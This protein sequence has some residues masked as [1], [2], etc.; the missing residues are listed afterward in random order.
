MAPTSQRWVAGSG[1]PDVALWRFRTPLSFH[2]VDKTI[3][4]G[5]LADTQMFKRDE[6]AKAYAMQLQDSVKNSVWRYIGNLS[7]SKSSTCSIARPDSELS[8]R[9]DNQGDGFVEGTPYGRIGPAKVSFD[10]KKA[11]RLYKKP[12]AVQ[13]ETICRANEDPGSDWGADASLQITVISAPEGTVVSTQLFRRSARGRS[14]YDVQFF[15]DN[16]SKMRLRAV[17]IGAERAFEKVK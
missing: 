11:R 2:S 1:S 9:F 16:N 3:A 10:H 17:D 12:A 14:H 4:F 15:F 6:A 8:L 5:A 13:A 7:Y